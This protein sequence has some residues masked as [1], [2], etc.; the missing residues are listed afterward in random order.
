MLSF[1]TQHNPPA[2]LVGGF[3]FAVKYCASLNVKSCAN[4]HREILRLRRNVK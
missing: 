4:A 2:G 3:S 1:H